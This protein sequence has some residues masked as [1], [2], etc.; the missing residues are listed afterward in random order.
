MPKKNAFPALPR[1]FGLT[2]PVRGR[3]IAPVMKTPVTVTV[4]GAAGNIAYSLLFRIAAGEMLGADQPVILKLLEITPCLEKLQGVVMELEDCA[5]PLVKEIVATDDPAVAFKNAD[6]C[7]L[8]GSVPRKA[9]MERKDLLGI[10]G[11]VFIGQGKAIA[12][13]AAPGCKVFVVGNPCNTNCLIALHNATGMP[14]E[15]FFAMTLLDE[16]RA[17]SQLAAKAGVHVSDVTNMCIW[18]NHSATQYPDFT[19]AK[20]CGKPVTDVITD[21][22][23]LKGEFIKTV[24]QRGAAIIAARGLSS[25]ASAANAALM[26]VKNLVTPTPEG[27]WFSVSTI[28]DGNS[29]GLPEGIICSMPTRTNADGTHSIVEGLP[30]DDFSKEKIAASCQEL[31]EERACVLG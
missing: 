31:L 13:N 4:T 24:Q 28:S 14:K 10:N 25:A 12:E 9:G 23:W 26:T 6:W 15:N 11:K 18:G 29:Y 3:I 21:T 7:M 30:L 17:K 27:D 5:F 20:I 2:C 16:Y 19:N 8:V 22:E 1:D